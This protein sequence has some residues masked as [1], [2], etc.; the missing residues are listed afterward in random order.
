M[1]K[2][3]HGKRKKTLGPISSALAKGQQGALMSRKKSAAVLKKHTEARFAAGVQPMPSQ[4]AAVRR[5]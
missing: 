5:A 2:E 1:G 4:L 3:M